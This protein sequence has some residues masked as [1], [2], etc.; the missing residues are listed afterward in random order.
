MLVDADWPLIGNKSGA[1]RLGFAVLLKFTR[2]PA[3]SPLLRGSARRRGGIPGRPGEGRAAAVRRDFQ[4]SQPHAMEVRVSAP[5]IASEIHSGNPPGSRAL[6]EYQVSSGS[7]GTSAG[8]HHTLETGQ[9]SVAARDAA[10]PRWTCISRSRCWMSARGRR[11][12]HDRQRWRSTL[13]PR[14]RRSPCSGRIG[15][16]DLGQPNRL[17]IKNGNLYCLFG[18]RVT[19]RRCEPYRDSRQRVEK[20]RGGGRFD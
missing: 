7:R 1:T 19:A 15:R 9:C 8:E 18:K 5:G 4:V 16:H 2:S 10:F 12:R 6:P 11:G 20:E 17:R 3:G 13:R 14:S